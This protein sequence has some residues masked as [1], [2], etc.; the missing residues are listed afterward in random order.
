M[1]QALIDIEK[2]ALKSQT[3]GEYENAI[4]LW[5]EI[6]QTAPN[7]EHGNAHHNLAHCY[8]MTTQFDEAERAYRNAVEREPQNEMFS[9]ALQSF[10]DAKRSGVI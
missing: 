10:V 5:C 4:K 1:T 6:I 3:A 8:F 9:N 7:W 2:R